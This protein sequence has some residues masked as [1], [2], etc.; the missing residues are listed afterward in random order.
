MPVHY[1]MHVWVAEENPSGV[2]A[3]LNPALSC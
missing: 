2:F 1:D 3:L